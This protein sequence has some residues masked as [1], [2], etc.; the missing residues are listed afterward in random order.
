ML[1]KKNMYNN[2]KRNT[3][4]NEYAETGRGVLKRPLTA[5]GVVGKNKPHAPLVT[6]WIGFEFASD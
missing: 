1:A 6:T 3:P 5:N 4:V 2:H